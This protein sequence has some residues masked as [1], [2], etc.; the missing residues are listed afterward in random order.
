MTYEAE[1]LTECPPKSISEIQNYFVIT[2]SVKICEVGVWPVSG[3][4]MESELAPGG[5]ITNWATPTGYT[6]AFVL[7]PDT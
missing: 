4:C 1:A 7:C 5:C 3:F 2:L 6:Q